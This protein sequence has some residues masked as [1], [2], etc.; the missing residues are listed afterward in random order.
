VDNPT[1]TWG[2]GFSNGG[3]LGV[4]KAFDQRI[5]CVRGGMNAN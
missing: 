1:L 4:N 2:V 3:V 5:W